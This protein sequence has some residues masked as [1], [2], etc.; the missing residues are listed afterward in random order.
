MAF[1]IYDDVLFCNL[2]EVQNTIPSDTQVL[3]I[4]GILSVFGLQ[5]LGNFVALFEI[6]DVRCLR[7]C[8]DYYL[9]FDRF[10]YPCK[11]LIAYRLQGTLVLLEVYK[12][13]A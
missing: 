13:H 2:N 3:I 8:G 1:H 12:S 4:G 10:G 9:G 11:T 7:F 6:T 5:Y